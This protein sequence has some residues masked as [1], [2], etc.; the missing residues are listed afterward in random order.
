[1]CILFELNW[2]FS[3]MRSCVAWSICVPIS[4]LY[5]TIQNKEWYISISLFESGMWRNLRAVCKEGKPHSVIISKIWF[6]TLEKHS[7]PNSVLNILSRPSSWNSL[8]IVNPFKSKFSMDVSFNTLRALWIFSMRLD[9][10]NICLW[11]MANTCSWRLL[12]IDEYSE[13]FFR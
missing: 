4:C 9:V 6:L 2:E 11:L 8:Q 13:Y 7:P 10:F 5:P 3:R 12:R 1:M